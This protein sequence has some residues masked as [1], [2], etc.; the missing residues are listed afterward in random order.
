VAIER[1]RGSEPVVAEAFYR[2]TWSLDRV[3]EGDIGYERQM[4]GAHF[5]VEC[6]RQFLTARV[7]PLLLIVVAVAMTATTL[8]RSCRD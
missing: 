7:R 2:R 3:A 4:S 8:S 5:R 6:Q 1:R